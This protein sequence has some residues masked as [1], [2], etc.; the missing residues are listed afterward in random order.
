MQDRMLLISLF[1]PLLLDF[2]LEL[3][4]AEEEEDEGEQEAWRPQI[5]LS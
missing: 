1:G 3:D 5:L 4:P 2:S